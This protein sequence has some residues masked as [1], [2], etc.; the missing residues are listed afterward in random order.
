MTLLGCAL[1]LRRRV[2]AVAAAAGGEYY[3][4]ST[5]IF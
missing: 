4:A 1:R 3:T 5:G 2:E